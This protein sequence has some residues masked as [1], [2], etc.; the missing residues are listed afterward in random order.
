MVDIPNGHSMLLIIMNG[1][2]LITGTISIIMFR[3]HDVCSQQKT[4]TS[5]LDARYLKFEDAGYRLKKQP[6]E[7]FYKKNLLK[8][9]AKFTVSESLF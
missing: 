1:N 4:S 5:V 2:Y 3:R 8:S 9:F 6:T 7:V